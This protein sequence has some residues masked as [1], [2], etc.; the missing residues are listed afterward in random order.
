MTRS[1]GTG[2][3]AFALRLVRPLVLG[4]GV[5]ALAEPQAWA[6]DSMLKF[7]SR[8]MYQ[9]AG[10]PA[11]AGQLALDDLARTSA[12]GPGRYEVALSINLRPFDRR[13]ID[14]MLD[15]QDRLQPCLSS[16]LLEELG[17]SL[18]TIEDSSQLQQRCVDLGAA[19]P[20]A[21]SDFNASE[22]AL[23]V[24]IP[25]IAM[26]RDSHR[27]VSAERWDPGI[28]SAFI[29]YQ[30][31]AQHGRNADGR[32][33]QNQDLY[34][35][36]GINL[37]AWRLRSSQSLRNSDMGR[38]WQ[39][40]YTYVE[41]DIPG[42]LARMTL[43]ETY[44]G[45]DVFRSVPIVGVNLASDMAMLPDSAQ[46]YAPI[47][48]GVAQTRA[49]VEVLQNGYPLYSTYVSPGPYE[50]DDLSTGGGSG[51]LE[52]VVTE[53]DGQVRRF[54]QSYSGLSNLMR[55]GVWRYR[56]SAG[57]YN[58][59]WQNAQPLLWQGDVAMGIG[60]HSTLYGGLMFSDFYQAR[61]LGVAR[62]F[63]GFGALSFDATLS[64]AD[65]GQSSL[66]GASYALRYG[67]SFASRT[68]LRFA[69]YRYS[70]ENY[71]DFEEAL[72]ERTQPYPYVGN[73]R[74][75]LEASVY[76]NLGRYSSVSLNMSQETYWR[77]D[78]ERTQFQMYFN[79]SH[80][81]IGYNFYAS[82][83]LSA[84]SDRS[85]RQFG[86]SVSVPLG[87]PSMRLSLDARR[88]G[89][90]WS[91]RAN[92]SGTLDQ[93][94]YSY[95]AYVDQQGGGARSGGVS[96]GYQ[97]PFAT[98]GGG[99]ARGG[100]YD[101]LSL[102]A[103]G[104][105]LAHEGG[106]A[107][108]P[109]VGETMGLV[110]VPDTPGVSVANTTASKTNAKGYALIPNLQPYRINQVQLHTDHLGPDVALDNGT[111]QLV[112]TRGAVVKATF[113]ARRQQPVVISASGHDGA[114]LPFGAKVRNTAGA[115]LGVVGQAGQ[116]ML[117]S[118]EQAQTLHVE[119]AQSLCQLH[120]D[121]DTMTVRDGYRLQALACDR[122]PPAT[123]LR[124]QQE[125]ADEA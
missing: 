7:Q 43:G 116:I 38:N 19:I 42:T 55:Q 35:L 23:S 6:S 29:N 37:G 100:H 74:S 59:P 41:R 18:G 98:V 85:D 47:I 91:E 78:Y 16:A 125:P 15:P 22:L 99:Y 14:F 109:H 2:R 97:A 53:A 81:G 3:P 26:R 80:R 119:W 108:G 110:H 112:P 49:R 63:G 58:S 46:S 67:K 95:N 61:N 12:L 21:F 83:S 114:P 62:D 117:A 93:N 76:Q 107:F 51:E 17:V 57:R 113:N 72:N 118:L 79:T 92:L 60:W 96:M 24:S 121:P 31:S 87:G 84:R 111:T 105:L 88:T 27:S 89:D 65:I 54:T 9:G 86:L 123:A 64:D 8:F 10:A 48:R 101:N 82:Q 50:L 73:R 30:A 28:N 36:S 68:T 120:L 33:S 34:L 90:Q 44:T 4:A 122:N 32:I 25:Q 11:D 71:R 106:I 103:S 1:S 104:A 94:R 124:A 39:R 13:E 66:Q 40:A 75:R 20:G 52:I 70:T 102:N 5:F 45:G 69:G 115:T 77:S 56:A